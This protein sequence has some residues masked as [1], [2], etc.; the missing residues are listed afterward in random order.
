MCTF[1]SLYIITSGYVEHMDKIQ[2]YNL[3][4]LKFSTIIL[5]SRNVQIFI[6]IS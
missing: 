3:Y 5:N 1:T 4:A 2:L 6:I